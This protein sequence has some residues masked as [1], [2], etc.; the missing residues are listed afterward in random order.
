MRSHREFHMFLRFPFASMRSS[1]ALLLKETNEFYQH[2]LLSL[3]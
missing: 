1:P 3:V 2:A